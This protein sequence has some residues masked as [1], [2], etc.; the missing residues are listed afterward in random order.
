V[1]AASA[2]GDWDQVMAQ[3]ATLVDDLAR[4]RAA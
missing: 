4:R 2:F 1:L 3:A